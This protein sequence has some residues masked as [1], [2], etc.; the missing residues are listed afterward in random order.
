MAQT[1]QT[2]RLSTGGLAPAEKLALKAARKTRPL[3]GCVRRPHRFRPGTVALR[4]IRRLQRITELLIPNLPFQRLV[5]EVTQEFRWGLRFQLTAVVALQET[6]ESYLVDR[7]QD[8]NYSA[9]HATRVT[10]APKDMQFA[11]RIRGERE[12]R[13][14]QYDVCIDGVFVVMVCLCQWRVCAD[15]VFSFAF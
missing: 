1:K 15:G 14:S 8:C 5:R 10:V 12:W 11:R 13:A 7:F 4:E 3:P 9:I 2:A 6:A